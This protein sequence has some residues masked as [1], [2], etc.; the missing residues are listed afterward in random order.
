MHLIGATFAKSVTGCNVKGA[1]TTSRVVLAI[2]KWGINRIEAQEKVD[3][4]RGP[5]SARRGTRAGNL[6]CIW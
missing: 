3:E 6:L 4:K 1:S 2:N 5:S